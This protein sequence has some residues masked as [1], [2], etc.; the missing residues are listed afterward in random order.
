MSVNVTSGLLG[1]LIFT[2]AVQSGPSSR[3]ELLADASA[4][5]GG[6]EDGGGEDEAASD[7]GAWA[8]AFVQEEDAEDGA[9]ERFHIEEDAGLGGWNLGHSPV[10]E[11]RSGSG[12]EEAA[13]RKC[14]PGS[15]RDVV[16]W[17]RAVEERNDEEQHRCSAGGAV[18]ADDDGA[19]AFHQMLV[20]QD[21][22]EGDDERNDYEQ[23]ANE[24]GAI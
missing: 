19:V 23:V 18:G 5:A 14:Q 11:K 3:R 21:P 10:P 15:E 16:D 6:D 7:S 8:E 17:Q 2:L 13:G 22:T 1:R 20:E 4:G 9:D 12:A 24:G